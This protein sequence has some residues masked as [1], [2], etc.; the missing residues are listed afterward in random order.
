MLSFNFPSLLVSPTRTVSSYAASLL[1]S[2]G[3]PGWPGEE[4]DHPVHLQEPELAL[5]DLRSAEELPWS[6]NCTLDSSTLTHIPSLSSP[7]YMTTLLTCGP[8]LALPPWYHTE[9][10][11]PLKKN[12]SQTPLTSPYSSVPLF[13]TTLSDLLPSTAFIIVWLIHICLNFN[14]F[15]C[16][17]CSFTKVQCQVTLIFYV[18]K[19]SI[20]AKD[21]IE[22]VQLDILLLTRHSIFHLSPGLVFC[23]NNSSETLWLRLHCQVY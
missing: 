9:H 23:I 21:E 12:S 6:C 17:T 1:L 18:H 2:P 19:K 22:L 4:W 20:T 8:S 5:P 15:L 10:L 7:S 3:S 13:I 16:D 14:I 11:V